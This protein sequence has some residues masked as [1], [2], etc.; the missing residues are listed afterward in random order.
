MSN[1]WK[2]DMYR[3][4]VSDM[5]NEGVEIDDEEVINSHLLEYLG[6]SSEEASAIRKEF[7]SVS[8][9]MDFE[10][11]GIYEKGFITDRD[12]DSQLLSLSTDFSLE[13]INSLANMYISTGDIEA[14]DRYFD[15]NRNTIAAQKQGKMFF[16]L[17]KTNIRLMSLS[18]LDDADN[19]LIITNR[20]TS[21]IVSRGSIDPVLKPPLL[22]ALTLL[23]LRHIKKENYDLA[24]EVLDQYNRISP[25]SDNYRRLYMYYYIR[26]G[27]FTS[28]MKIIEED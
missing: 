4:I 22:L 21:K 28:A 15:T 1:N 2:L 6:I 19:I 13:G 20:L 25:G 10:V 14:L 23:T 24:Q 26:K 8:E 5:W 3:Q 27:D 9:N 17:W 12:I 16:E 11:P 7:Y 18:P